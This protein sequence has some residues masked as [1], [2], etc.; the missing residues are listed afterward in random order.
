MSSGLD[1]ELAK[2]FVGQIL[3]LWINPEIQRRR[4]AGRITDDFRVHAVQVI[5][6]L[7]APTEIRLNEEIKA[8]VKGNFARPVAEND[9]VSLDELEKIDSIELTKHDPNAGHVTML[10]HHGSWFIAFDFRYN[11]ARSSLHLEAAREFLDAAAV[12]AE[13]S[14]FRAL[15]DNLFS[16]TELMAKSLLLMHDQL[17]FTSK[18]HG[19]VHARYNQWGKLGNVDRR[20]TE[21]LN[22]LASLRGSARYL[23]SDLLMH[24]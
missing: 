19:I 4:E 12:S 2:T 17:V 21:L 8:A 7:D 6:Y 14:H 1:S 15:I 10:F 24:A 23:S 5:M 16:A 9:L 13:K 22:R 18:T 20:Y 3:D 11:S